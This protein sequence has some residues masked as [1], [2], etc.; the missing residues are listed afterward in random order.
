MKQSERQNH[1]ITYFHERWVVM[2][3]AK[4]TGRAKAKEG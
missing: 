2:A 4:I 1:E 3:L